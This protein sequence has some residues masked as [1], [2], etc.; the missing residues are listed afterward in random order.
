MKRVVA[1]L[2]ILSLLVP[3]FGF[4]RV[5]AAEISPEAGAIAQEFSRRVMNEFKFTVHPQIDQVAISDKVNEYAQKFAGILLD[6]GLEPK[7]AGMI[8]QQASLSYG[9]SLTALFNAKP[10]NAVIQAYSSK[11][12]DLFSQQHL[13]MDTQSKI[14]DMTSDNLESFNDLFH[15]MEEIAQ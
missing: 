7:T 5:L 13:N 9:Q 6:A 14:V 3:G 2:F 8:M 10:Y 4:S 1:A 15:P 11:I 12:A